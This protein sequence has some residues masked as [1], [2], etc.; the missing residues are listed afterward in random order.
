MEIIHPKNFSCATIYKITK[1]EIDKIDFSLCNQPKETLEQFYK[2]QQQKP[3]I[4]FNGGF[5]CMNTG[6]TCFTFVDDYNVI[7]IQQN[8]LEGIGI[9]N[10]S[11]II[12]DKYNPSYRDFINGYPVLIKNGI[13][14]T[15][16]IGS[17]I[18]YKAR[19]TILGFDNNYIYVI[20]IEL[21]GYTFST[22]KNLLLEL[23]ISNAINLDGGGSTRLLYKGQL[24]SKTT[25]S[26]PV[27]NVVAIYFKQKPTMIYRVQ[28]GAFSNK[29]NAN[30]YLQ[31][32]R[33]IPDTIGA[34]YKNAYIRMIDNLYKVQV[35]A[36]SKK[37]NAVKVLNDLVSKGYSAFIVN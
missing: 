2:R 34:G 25:Y 8:L 11:E 26:R 20:I 5:F 33:N 19:R 4:L 21:P 35:G 31:T 10:N 3:D 16:T 36:F 14:V 32:I 12:I 9:K 7:T 28:T 1:G 37:E 29:E 15:T 27:D 24:Q 13:P 22:I 6:D 30:K 18:D 17:E 23:K